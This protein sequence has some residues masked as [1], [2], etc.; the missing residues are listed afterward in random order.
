[1]SY[2]KKS[3]ILL[4]SVF[5]NMTA[6]IFP[7]EAAGTVVSEDNII[8]AG[9]TE[10]PGYAY[11]DVRGEITGADIEYAYKI[12]Q[13]SG[14]KIRTV[15]FKDT[16]TAFKALDTGAIDTLFDIYRSEDRMQKYLFSEQEIGRSPLAV[17][18]RKNDDRFEYG[19]IE[20]LKNLIYG[21]ETGS[22]VI[23]KYK[24][25]CSKYGFVPEIRQFADR[26]EL[27]KA[28]DSSIV[29]A[30]LMGTGSVEGYR[31]IQNFSPIPYYLVFRKDAVKIKILVDSAMEQILSDDPL[32]EEKIVAKYTNSRKYEMDAFTRQEKEYI[33][34]H[35]NIRIAVV[36]NDAP[37]YSCSGSE[38]GILPDYYRGIASLIG[39]QFTFKV[40]DTHDKA[41]E[42]VVKGDADI[43]G[44]FNDCFV[45]AHDSGL[46]MTS[47]YKL[48]DAALITLSGTDKDRIKKIAVKQRSYNAIFSCLDNSMASKLVIYNNATES[49]TALQQK[50]VDAIICGMPSATWL[51]NQVNSPLY[52]MSALSSISF[53]LCGAVASHNDVLCSILDK[54]IKVSGYTFDGI[55]TNNIVQENTFRTFISRIPPV[56]LALFSV[57]MLALV[58]TLIIFSVLLIRRQRERAAVEKEKLRIE[59]LEKNTEERNQFFSNISH[60]M[61]TPLNAIIGFSSLAEKEKISPRA[62]EYISKIELS[63]N[64]LLD[65]INDTLTISKFN[66]GKLELH[67]EPLSLKQL[68]ES[69]LVPVKESAE[70][71][72]IL[73]I[74]DSSGLLDRIVLADRLNL[75]KIVLNLLSNAV[76]YTPAGG[77]VQFMITDEKKDEHTCDTIITVKDTGIGITKDFLPHI[78]DP[79]SQE[80]RKGYESNGTGLGLSIVKHLVDLMGGKI[81]VQSEKDKGTVFTV[82]IQL[83]QSKTADMGVHAEE[84]VSAAK[85]SGKRILLCEDNALNREIACAILKDKGMDIVM[86]EDG[87]SGV[88][89]FA[90]SGEKEFAAVLMDIRMPVMDGYE[91]V[92][93][94]RS[95]NRKDAATVPI[96]AMTA[97]A[98][99][100][101]IHKCISVGM[102][103][104]I[105]KPINPDNLFAVLDS[106]VR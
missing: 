30:G 57:I 31:T 58:I 52:S 101:D 40:Y 6:L 39:I 35:Q 42:A 53:E 2:F 100:D 47:S 88:K 3:L 32:Y 64:L 89:K 29:D 81:E 26:E 106:L 103:G 5:C 41:Y 46:R 10:Y 62:A 60:D 79:F 83:K 82:R 54:A 86:A 67:L 4:L 48:V 68:F 70:K 22:Y 105:A 18:V 71:K 33:Q 21:C 11:T 34:K 7:A 28:V 36:K 104:H 20:Q 72:H 97:D 23:T 61:R 44:M 51:I 98:F 69:V 63:G 78:Y 38:K 65:L 74:S 16:K 13:M 56:W 25:W 73:F 66:N 96:I 50:K 9:F 95:L 84:K 27:C 92:K 99:E 94:I 85:L 102:N 17:F 59:A 24:A 19:R 37:Y 87:S 15:L 8:S 12:A 91:A 49:I 75:E 45:S 55:V 76:K 1:M 80:R 14:M 90:D 43:L 77:T 93:A